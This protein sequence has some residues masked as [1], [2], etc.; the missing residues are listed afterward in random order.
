MKAVEQKKRCF[1]VREDNPLYCAYHD[2]EWGTPLRDDQSMYALFMLELFQAGLSWIT[3]LKKREAFATAFDGFDVEKIAAYDEEKITCLMQDASIIR[4]RGK[5]EAAIVNA[6]IVLELKREFGSFC[7]YLWSFS[8]GRVM[9]SPDGKP[10]ATS[11]VS[12]RISADL[13]RRGMRYAGSVTIHSF[14]QAA[15]IVNEHERTCYR[16]G[17]LMQYFTQDSTITE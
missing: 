11:P 7:N 14:L 17:E 15:G 13:K 4:S 6:K 10:R 5:I 3:L 12:D 1:W 16:Y 8:D 9:L 2:E